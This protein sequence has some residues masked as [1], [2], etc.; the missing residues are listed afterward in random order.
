MDILIGETTL[1]ELDDRF[2]TRPVDYVFIK[3]RKK[4]LHIFE[5]L[6]EGKRPLTAAEECFGT[7]LGF[8]R[9]GEFERAAREFAAHGPEDNLCRIFLDRC[10]DFLRTPPPKGW[11]GTWVF[12]IKK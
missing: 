10:R 9:R 3:G 7:G 4:P 12:D 11:K 6:C 2:M 5:V 1:R 8:Y